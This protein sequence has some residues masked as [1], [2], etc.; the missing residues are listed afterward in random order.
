MFGEWYSTKENI[1]NTNIGF[2]DELKTRGF[3]KNFKHGD[4][5]RYYRDG[6]I[7]YDAIHRYAEKCVNAFYK[8]DE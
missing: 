6:K 8:S 7:L 4:K 3:D 5:Y 2:Y 1:W